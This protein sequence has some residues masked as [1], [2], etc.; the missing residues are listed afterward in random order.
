MSVQIFSSASFQ[1]HIHRIFRLLLCGKTQR[2]LTLSCCVL[3]VFDESCQTE[4]GHFTH[5]VLSHQDVGCTQ[6]SVDVVHPLHVRHA[7]SN[8][9]GPSDRR[10][11]IL[12]LRI[13]LR[14]WV[15][16]FWVVLF[17]PERTC[18]PAEA[19]EA[20][21]LRPLSGSPISSLGTHDQNY[22]IKKTLYDYKTRYVGHH[23]LLPHLGSCT[24]S[25]CRWAPRTPRRTAA[26]TSRAAASSWPVLPAGRPPGT[27][28]RASG[29][30]WLLASYRSTYLWGN[31]VIKF[32]V[33][34][35]NKAL[36]LL[37][38]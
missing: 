20:S 7:R 32:S 26:P 27:W 15:C 5:Q 30:W 2:G 38:S 37:M 23:W 33:Q 21:S 3:I 16:E 36:E 18:R 25:R 11:F 8:L 1:L 28:C 13:I 31:S 19:D 17:L 9:D 6:I 22:S 10:D 35:L 14:I 12:I 29:S 34:L 24:L 4:V